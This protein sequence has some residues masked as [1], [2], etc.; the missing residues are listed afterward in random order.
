MNINLS[1]EIHDIFTR[2][3]TKNAQCIADN[4]NFSVKKELADLIQLHLDYIC[5]GDSFNFTRPFESV[6]FDNNKPKVIKIERA[7]F[8]GTTWWLFDINNEA[9]GFCEMPIDSLLTMLE[10]VKEQMMKLEK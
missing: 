2:C 10:V 6:I 3:A 1:N 4:V 5:N 9:Y 8:N 7:S